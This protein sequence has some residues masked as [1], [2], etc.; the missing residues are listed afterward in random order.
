MVES[1]ITVYSRMSYNP[2]LHAGQVPMLPV[3][4]LKRPSEELPQPRCTHKLRIKQ[5]NMSS[6]IQ[7][8]AYDNS[9]TNER[10]ILAQ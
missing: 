2:R 7:G 1:V 5:M 8:H 4:V 3:Q 6:P 9:T 10:G